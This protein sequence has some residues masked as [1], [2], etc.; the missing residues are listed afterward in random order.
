MSVKS[1]KRPGSATVV[2]AIGAL[3]LVGA[4][5]ARVVAQPTEVAVGND[6]IN[7]ITQRYDFPV[8]GQSTWY[9]ELIS[10]SQ[11]SISH[12]VFELNTCLSVVGAGVWD[13]SDLDTLLA[14]GQPELVDPD[15]TCG[16]TG[17]KFDQ[18]FEDEETR[19]YWFTVDGNYAE[20][21][22]G[23]ASKGGPSCDSGFSITG[24]SNTCDEVEEP[25][26]QI[27]SLVWED[28]NQNGLQDAVEVLEPG[29]ADVLIELFEN[30]T[31]TGD[32]IADQLT[33]DLGF[34]LFTGLAEGIYCVQVTPP[35]G[36]VFTLQQVG[37]DDT[38]DSDATDE[39]L[40][41]NILLPGDDL[42]RD[43]GLV[44]EVI[45]VELLLF[46]VAD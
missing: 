4:G 21:S 2:L 10:G 6:E 12:V 22:I 24:P 37:G 20:D 13:G 17:L 14:G 31:C 27:G 30:G 18:G 42:D 11:P 1:R 7:F 25:T 45:P 19:Y 38:I 32:P 3:L 5:G 8:A 41:L 15:P 36:F 9:Y 46:E 44:E 33:S 28:L 34:Y 26:Y 16:G 23:L 35:Q 39:G 29:I 40:I 43:A